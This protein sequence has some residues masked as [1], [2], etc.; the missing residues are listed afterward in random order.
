MKLFGNKWRRQF[1]CWLTT[2]RRKNLNGAILWTTMKIY[3]YQ[4]FRIYWM[5][6]RDTSHCLHNSGSVYFYNSF[7]THYDISHQKKSIWNYVI[8]II[9]SHILGVHSVLLL[10]YDI[11]MNSIQY[12]IFP[13]LL[14][15][16]QTKKVFHFPISLSPWG[17]H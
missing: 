13:F 10:L 14:I 1:C 12:S 3:E 17:K 5:F 16:I 7:E 6:N 11:F 15:N 9:C 8:L 2:F 4:C